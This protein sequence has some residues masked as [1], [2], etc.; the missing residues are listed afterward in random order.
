MS[1]VSFLKIREMVGLVERLV[2]MMML[3]PTNLSESLVL[4]HGCLSSVRPDP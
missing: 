4:L 1:E 2:G 3:E